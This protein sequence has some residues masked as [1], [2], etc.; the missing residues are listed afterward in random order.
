MFGVSGAKLLGTLR[1][2]SVTIQVEKHR[3]R[4]QDGSNT[5]NQS[6]SRIDTE[7]IKLRHEI[8]LKLRRRA[9]W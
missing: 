4:H 2:D 9:V 1:A 7:S 5:A 6:P 8:S 3:N